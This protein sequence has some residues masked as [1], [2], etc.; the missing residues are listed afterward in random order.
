MIFSTSYIRVCGLHFPKED[1][2]KLVHLVYKLVTIP[3]LEPPLIRTWSTLLGTL[4]KY[5]LV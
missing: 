1:H 5:I 2:I 3:D 4:L